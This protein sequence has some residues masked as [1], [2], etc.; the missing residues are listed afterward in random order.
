MTSTG[1][2]S[3]A[4]ILF[5]GRGSRKRPS[6]TSVGP[7]SGGRADD[8]SGKEERTSTIATFVAR[9]EAQRP[10]WPFTAAGLSVFVS[11][12]IRKGG[13]EI[14]WDSVIV[15]CEEERDGTLTLRVIVANPDWDRP[16]QIAYI[17]SRPGDT[18]SLTP[19]ASNL[20]HVTARE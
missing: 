12:W 11:Q 4:E 1:D 16:L 2:R 9:C 19:L 18:E 20:D 13:R 6:N 15:R 5:T 3:S 7:G 10:E 17:R 8:R 14:L